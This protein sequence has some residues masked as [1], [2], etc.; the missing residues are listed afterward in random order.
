MNVSCVKCVLICFTLFACLFTGCGGG[1]GSSGGNSKIIGPEGGTLGIT[2]V[3]NALY[4]VRLDIPAGALAEDTEINI[5]LTPTPTQLLGS[6]TAAGISVQ[7]SPAGLT[8]LSPITLTLPYDDQNN[9]NLVDGTDFL[10]SSVI[11]LY[12]DEEDH[13]LE[14]LDVTDQN[15]ESNLIS[16]QTDHFSTYL[17]IIDTTATDDDTTDDT[18]D[19]GT[20]DTTTP[21][22]VGEHLFANPAFRY[23][24]E[25]IPTIIVQSSPYYHLTV[26]RTHLYTG[27]K[28][29]LDR[30][31]SRSGRG[32]ECVMAEDYLSCTFDAQA[33]FS[34]VAQS[35]DAAS[36]DWN[37]EF[38]EEHTVLRTYEVKDDALDTDSTDTTGRIYCSIAAGDDQTSVT[39]TWGTVIDEEVYMNVDEE[40]FNLY[41]DMLAIRMWANY[42]PQAEEST[43]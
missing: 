24:S 17:S 43:P 36:W 5:A 2:D 3:N 32:A 12:A 13:L 6:I 28:A 15:M 9:D 20:D 27:V 11:A 19:D 37:C 7:M 10:E 14:P 34:K 31:L 25:G 1:S 4:G 38:V 35:A 40:V 23:D 29:L 42:N 8:F 30:Y 22:I 41:T 26:I 39:I 33:V 16:F 21:L 18:T